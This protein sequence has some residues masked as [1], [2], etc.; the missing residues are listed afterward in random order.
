MTGL[1]DR[2]RY[3]RQMQGMTLRELAG[4]VGVSYQFVH[5][6]ETGKKRNTDKLPEFA[7]ALHVSVEH[8]TGVKKCES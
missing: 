6:L 1:G 5:M 2:I 8:L 3:F 4:L 7:A